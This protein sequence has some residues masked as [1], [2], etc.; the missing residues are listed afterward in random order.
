[1]AG[2]G[3]YHEDG[4]RLLRRGHPNQICKSHSLEPNG[5]LAVFYLNVKQNFYPFMMN[6]TYRC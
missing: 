6:D 4:S 2:S 5:Y 3:S 1:L